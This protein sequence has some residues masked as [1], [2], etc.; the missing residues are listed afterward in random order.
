MKT[1]RKSF[2]EDYVCKCDWDED[3]FVQCGESGIVLGK[4][5][6]QEVFDAENPLEALSEAASDKKSYITAFFEAFPK[7]PSTFIRG[8]GKSVEEAEQSAW[9]QFQKYKNCQE[10]EFERR[11]Y[12]NGGG[13][14]KHCGMFKSNVFPPAHN[15]KICNIP[16]CFTHDINKDWYC[17]E[18]S[19][20]IPE[21]LKPDWM[22]RHERIKKYVE[23]KKC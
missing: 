5:S 4:G 1:A 11:G 15:C 20:Q 19:T 9:N 7:E 12:D 17:E 16:T 3:C 23:E 10:H 6:L 8:E 18:H 22:I 13:I 14:C 21:D 2:G